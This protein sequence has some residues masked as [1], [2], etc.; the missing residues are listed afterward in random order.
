[1]YK[2]VLHPEK[3]IK[4]KAFVKYLFNKPVLIKFADGRLIKEEEYIQNLLNGKI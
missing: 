4:V 2:L 1:M 3:G